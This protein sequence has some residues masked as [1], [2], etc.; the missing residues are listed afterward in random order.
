MGDETEHETEKTEKRLW[1]LL[2]EASLKT[3]EKPKGYDSPKSTNV[4][5]KLDVP[6][7][8]SAAEPSETPAYRSLSGN[9]PVKGEMRAQSEAA[10]SVTDL[11]D[12]S[13]KTNRIIGADKGTQFPETLTKGQ[14]EA[15]YFQDQTVREAK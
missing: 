4:G 7:V 13:F 5:D 14:L 12:V 9:G 6:K 11:D 15:L 8:G 1:P 3:S 10:H 2:A